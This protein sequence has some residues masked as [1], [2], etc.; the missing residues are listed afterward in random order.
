[1]REKIKMVRLLS[2]EE[3]VGIIE[4]SDRGWKISYP[5]IIVTT[6]GQTSESVQVTFAPFCPAADTDSFDF[7]DLYVAFVSPVFD[8]LAIR[9]MS[10]MDFD[11]EKPTE[12]PAPAPKKRV[13]RKKAE[14][15]E[16]PKFVK[17]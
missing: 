9:Y 5:M 4:K 10:V 7:S 14:D 17:S 16:Q 6:L 11:E 12:A 2:G 15:S 1:M 13:P 3:L 8:G